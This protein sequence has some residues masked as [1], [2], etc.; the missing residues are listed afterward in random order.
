[1]KLRNLFIV[2]A[3]L[4]ALFGVGFMVVP[5]FLFNLLGFSIEA[6]GPLAM[7]Y[8]GIMVFGVS[9]LTF[10]A[11]NSED[12][13]ARRAIVLSLIIIYSLLPIFH[14]GTQLFLGKGNIMLWGMNILH[15]AF[16][17]LYGI[18]YFRKTERLSG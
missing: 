16:A 15:I 10:S 7:R 5:S 6:D 12:S 3:I 2:N 11:R 1:M 13:Q 9:V 17:I 14:I 8:M 18:A 4:A